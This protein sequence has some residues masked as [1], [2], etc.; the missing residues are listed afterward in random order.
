LIFDSPPIHLHHL[1]TLPYCTA[2]ISFLLAFIFLHCPDLH[3]VVISCL[4]ANPFR[5]TIIPSPTNLHDIIFSSP[6]ISIQR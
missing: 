1:L 2:T 4:S 6:S 5:F 3:F